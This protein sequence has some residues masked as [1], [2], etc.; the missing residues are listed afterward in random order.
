MQRFLWPASVYGNMAVLMI[1]AGNFN[2]MLEVLYFLVKSPD[3][4]IGKMNAKCLEDMFS[5]CMM[6]AHV[7][8]AIV[9]ERKFIFISYLRIYSKNSA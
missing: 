2:K 8:G 3:A 9:S 1:R 5:A 7:N 4:T 6:R